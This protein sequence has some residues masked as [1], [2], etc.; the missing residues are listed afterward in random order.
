MIFP[1]SFFSFGFYKRLEVILKSLNFFHFFSFILTTDRQ[2]RL[3]R[4][5]VS[6]LSAECDR[7]EAGGNYGVLSCPFPFSFFSF[8]F[9]KRLEV[10]LK[11]LNFFHFFSFIL[12][13]GKRFQNNFKSFVKAKREE[14]KRK[15]A[16]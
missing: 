12:T 9:Y 15:N 16:N 10:I 14:R 5:V 1:F 7:R 3:M 8:G 4:I 13:K 6:S 11:S 2:N